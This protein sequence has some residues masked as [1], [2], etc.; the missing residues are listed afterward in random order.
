[1]K[2]EITISDDI[3]EKIAEALGVKPEDRTFERA[4][5]E[6]IENGQLERPKRGTYAL[7]KGANE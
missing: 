2:T 1:V 6:G 4:L 7:G 3:V 5:E